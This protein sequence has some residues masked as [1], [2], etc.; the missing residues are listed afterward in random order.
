MIRIFSMTL[1]GHD[2]L[3]PQEALESW[4]KNPSCIPEF[5]DTAQTAVEFALKEKFVDPYKMAVGGLSRGGFIAAHL[6]AREPKFR[7]ILGYAPLTRFT[8][9]LS[10]NHLAPLLSDRHI[11]LYIGNDDARVG[12]AH[13]FDFCQELVKHKKARS[14][15]VELFITPSIGREGHGTSPEIFSQGAQWI[16]NCLS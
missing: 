11:R 3:S 4:I 1:P 10:L 14:A 16:A 7:F 13:C 8:H 12:T 5:L 2:L 9:E 6:A 15:Q